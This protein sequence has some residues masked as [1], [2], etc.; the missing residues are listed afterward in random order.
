[1]GENKLI[2]ISMNIAKNKK[3]SILET[4][5]N[6]LNVCLNEEIEYL[7]SLPP[8]EEGIP[9]HDFLHVCDVESTNALVF[10]TRSNLGFGV[11]SINKTGLDKPVIGFKIISTDDQFNYTNVRAA[12]IEDEEFALYYKIINSGFNDEENKM[13][14]KSIVTTFSNREA[15]S[16]IIEF[17]QRQNISLKVIWS[18]AQKLAV[19]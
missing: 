1:M 16:R 6:E 8:F 5:L 12:I 7:K 13:R 9:L 15:L 14:L 4:E 18:L 2:V 11:F 19:E 3:H 10:I 17:C